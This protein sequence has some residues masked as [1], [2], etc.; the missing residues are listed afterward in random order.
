MNIWLLGAIPGESFVLFARISHEYGDTFSSNLLL[1]SYSTSFWHWPLNPVSPLWYFTV[2]P[3][4]YPLSSA[5]YMF[6]T[7]LL[8]IFTH[9]FFQKFW[10]PWPTIS[11][12]W[13]LSSVSWQQLPSWRV[14]RTENIWFF[15]LNIMWSYFDFF[16]RLQKI[17]YN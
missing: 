12:S 10:E 5:S 4:K 2:Y 16:L 15:L 6:S 3:W 14:V 13:P 9:S 11:A 1:T 7:Y 17:F 8:R